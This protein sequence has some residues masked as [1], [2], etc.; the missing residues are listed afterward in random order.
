MRHCLL[1]FITSTKSWW[2]STHMCLLILIPSWLVVSDVK[3]VLVS[4]QLCARFRYSFSLE[5]F[6]FILYDVTHYISCIFTFAISFLMPWTLVSELPFKWL[7]GSLAR[8]WPEK[9]STI[10]GEFPQGYQISKTTKP[11][12]YNLSASLASPPTTPCD[13]CA[14][15]FYWL[16][17][18][19]MRNV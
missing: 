17:G 12:S 16:Q 11:F 18:H 3:G 2:I 7:F 1:A 9:P 13:R 4:M 5:L 14:P 8:T 19:C 15:K 6:M 10:C